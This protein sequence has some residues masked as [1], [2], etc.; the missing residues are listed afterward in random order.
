M[1][2]LSPSATQIVPLRSTNTS[3]GCCSS[4]G[5]APGPTPLQEPWS[6]AV[7]EQGFVYVADTW[8]HRIVKFSQTLQYMAAWG[9]PA[10]QTSP[11]GPLDLF[12]PRDIMIGEDGSVLITDTGHNRIISYTRDGQPMADYGLSG[13]ELGKFQEPVSLARDIQGRIYIA[14]AWN[15][16]IQRFERGFT[17]APA[18]VNVPWT[19]HEVPDKPYIATLSEGR[20]LA[21]VPENG[22]L[23]LFDANLR[24]VGTWRLEAGSKPIGVAPTA[25]G[26]FVFT[27]SLHDQLQIVPGAKVS[28]LFK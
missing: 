7:D 10:A 5:P 11:P 28:E 6:L 25:D 15:G 3:P 20:V 23:M 9:R 22:S 26:G 19:S 18:S 27:D 21:T 24:L 8:N 14:D 12:G 16:R 17:G 13:T 1:R 4:P 2:L